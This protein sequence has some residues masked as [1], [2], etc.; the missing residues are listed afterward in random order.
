[1]E[2]DLAVVG[3]RKQIEELERKIQFLPNGLRLREN[4]EDRL[5]DLCDELARHTKGR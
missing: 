2:T 1:M 3:L 4:L 5:Y